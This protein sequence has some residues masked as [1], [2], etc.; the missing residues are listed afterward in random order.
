MQPSNRSNNTRPGY[1]SVASASNEFE[2]IV[3]PPDARNSGSAN[4]SAASPSRRTGSARHGCLLELVSAQRKRSSLQALENLSRANS[5]IGTLAALLSAEAGRK[6]NSAQGG[7]QLLSSVRRRADIPD[8]Y[9]P[10]G[11]P[12]VVRNECSAVNTE[13]TFL[14]RPNL[15][16]WI[17]PGRGSSTAALTQTALSKP[18]ML[19]D[20]LLVAFSDTAQ[21]KQP[22][23]IADSGISGEAEE[24]AGSTST[25]KVDVNGCL[26]KAGVVPLGTPRV[27]IPSDASI[28]EDDTTSA[29]RLADLVAEG[30]TMPHADFVRMLA[31]NSGEAAQF[32]NYMEHGLLIKNSYRRVPCARY[33]YTDDFGELAEQMRA[34]GEPWLETFINGVDRTVRPTRG[35][36]GQWRIRVGAQWQFADSK[37]E[38]LHHVFMNAVSHLFLD[39]PTDPYM[40]IYPLVSYEMLGT[41]IGRPIPAYLVDHE[42]HILQTLGAN[43]EIEAGRIAK[44]KIDSANA[45]ESKRLATAE[46]KQDVKDNHVNSITQ[47]SLCN[48][49]YDPHRVTEGSLDRLIKLTPGDGDRLALVRKIQTSLAKSHDRQTVSYANHD[50]SGRDNLCWLR[51]GWLSVLSSVSPEGLARR[52]E[53]I[54]TAGSP[55]V[56][57]GTMLADIAQLFQA[58]PA[59]FMHCDPAGRTMTDGRSHPAHLGPD[60]PSS[61]VRPIG[62]QSKESPACSQNLEHWLKDMQCDLAMNFRF[63][64]RG[65]ANEVESLLFPRT[66][67]SS[68]MLI[69]LHRALHV[70]AL[71]IEAGLSESGG[72]EHAWSTVSAQLRLAAVAGTPLAALLELPDSDDPRDA[73]GRSASII[74]HF[75]NAPI[76]WL[77]RE[78][79]E[80]YFPKKTISNGLAPMEVDE[81]FDLID[82]NDPGDP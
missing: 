5:E 56:E 80:V 71:I 40:P 65:I 22:S 33:D 23:S 44:Q 35:L 25:M 57:G 36:E 73:E 27:Q 69:C 2:T 9:V 21:A 18:E 74:E 61:V 12:S 26:K 77:E 29:R 54:C 7:P 58:D 1:R 42:A 64:N 67:A 43:Q 46:L 16:S 79:F 62:D 60:G 30:I 72:G 15:E 75:R 6:C 32:F 19:T 78:H 20:T 10:T 63:E 38:V 76:I 14:L 45:Q 47:L 11:I 13:P 41:A 49:F 48:D 51:S 68:D 66:F 4:Q 82:L 50:V 28:P 37:G 8:G 81:V 39:G 70:P 52:F 31:E 3:E 59:G 53:S 55:A 34:K 17:S 24:K